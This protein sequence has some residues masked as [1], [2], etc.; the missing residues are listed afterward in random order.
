[1]FCVLDQTFR[2]VRE[3]IKNRK[4]GLSAIYTYYKVIDVLF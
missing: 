3:N 1:M 2:D 4:D